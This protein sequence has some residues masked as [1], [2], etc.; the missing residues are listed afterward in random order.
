VILALAEHDRGELEELSLEALTFGRRLAERIN[1]PL[2]A[3]LFGEEARPLAALLRG[4]GG[5][6][7]HIVE[8]D[9]LDAYAPAAWAESIVQLTEDVSPLLVLAAGSERGNEVM[10]HVA[11]RTDLP[12]AVNCTEVEP[13]EEFLV[14]RLRWGGSLLEEA[15]LDA[16]VKLLT[17]A[18][19]AIA[20]EKSPNPTEAEVASFNPTLSDEDLGVRVTGT[21]E[22]EEGAVSLP[23]A[24]VVVGGGRGLGGADEFRLL[25]ELAGLLGG[26]V[27]CSRAVTS[28][29]W[30]P[31]SDQIGQTGTRIAPDLYIA[32]G[33]S[34]A[35]QHMVGCKG[36][37]R[38]LVVN[39]DPHAPILAKADYAVIGDV[40]AVVPALSEEIRRARSGNR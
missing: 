36:A 22:P 38:I 16:P 4:Y 32:C 23:R 37:K 27:G 15:R 40:R 11:A 8:H 1:V 3:V 14:T 19:Q 26:A 39:T 35:I 24:R 20:A 33:I 12:L 31:H 18:P 30:R 29:G 13:G 25:E 7:V 6:T 2:H 21:V 9:R 5:S 10:A 34:G 17:V 28:L